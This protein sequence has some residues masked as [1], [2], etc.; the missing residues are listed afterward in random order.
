M[1]T[2]MDDQIGRVVKA[3]DE[4]GMRNNTL[5]FFQSDNGGPRSA[6]V[7]GEVDTSGG[8]IPADKGP[9]RD[10]KA[11]LYEGGTRV[12]ALANW[13]GR[14]KPGSIINQPSHIV[15][16]YP[17]L[18][19]LAGVSSPKGK[20]LDGLNIWPAISG[21]RTSKRD[22]IVY[23]IEPFRA[24]LRK[25]DWKLVWQ[26]TLPSR[27]ELFNLAQDPSEKTN[28]A[29]TKTSIVS[30]LKQRIERLSG[31]EASPPLFLK[32]AIG[33]VRS[34]LLTSVSTPDEVEEEIENQ[35]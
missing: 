28:L 5:I 13:P 16:M 6:A 10:G 1:I 7:T 8:T 19:T 34:V 24:A 23:N 12:V 3:L 9:F 22:E 17:T 21:G 27:L 4:R 20:P 14:I 35:P 31:E 15:D 33:A 2:A 29:D 18:T 26:V 32:E 30:E 11:S 25:G